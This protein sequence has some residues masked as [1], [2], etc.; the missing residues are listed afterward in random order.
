MNDLAEHL[1]FE[2]IFLYFFLNLLLRSFIIQKTF[3][4]DLAP[5][6]LKGNRPILAYIVCEISFVYLCY[7]IISMPG[8]KVWLAITILIVVRLAMD[9]FSKM[10]AIGVYC[11][12][13]KERGLEEE[14]KFAQKHPFK[15][16]AGN[17][18]RKFWRRHD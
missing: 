12:Y 6:W 8:L 9:L 11:G 7:S 18:Q 1:P 13:L 2:A 14:L 4:V 15:I 16:L 10:R 3:P 5:D 17:K